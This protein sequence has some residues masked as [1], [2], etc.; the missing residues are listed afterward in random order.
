MD[1]GTV[2]SWL[3]PSLIGIALL[4]LLLPNILI[5]DALPGTTQGAAVEAAPV[6]DAI[7]AHWQAVGK[8]YAAQAE[9]ANARQVNDTMAARWQTVANY[10]AAQWERANARQV[11]D[12][13]AARWQAVANYYAAQQ[14]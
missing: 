3:R 13:M 14:K 12:T 5:A 1:S 6:D 8:Y 4:I 7:T 10:Y 11:N 2:N 9:R